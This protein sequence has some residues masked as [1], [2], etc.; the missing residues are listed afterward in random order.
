MGHSDEAMAESDD[1]TFLRFYDEF[2]DEY[3]LAYG[4]GWEGA[5]ER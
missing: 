3:H 5:G 4:G 2:A 1:A